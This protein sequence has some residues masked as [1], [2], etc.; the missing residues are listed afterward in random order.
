MIFFIVILLWGNSIYGNIPNKMAYQIMV[1]DPN[2]KQIKANKDIKLRIEVRKNEQDGTTVFGQDFDAKTDKLG[3]CNII[4]DI[5]QDMDWTSGEFNLVTI[6]DGEI[7]GASS[8]CSVP[9]AFMAEAIDGIIKEE[10]IIGTWI[11]RGDGNQAAYL[12]NQD[13]TGFDYGG[14]GGT[15]TWNI[16]P[17]GE[18]VIIY[19]EKLP[20]GFI[21]ASNKGVP[22]IFGNQIVCDKDYYI[23][24]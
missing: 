2:T 22:L 13:K 15:F 16:T 11:Y 4:V 24:K 23:K 6:I 10:D 7:S 20:D 19:D 1:L 14:V 8:I 18:L 5:P 12:F 3:I 9:Y 21:H 17:I